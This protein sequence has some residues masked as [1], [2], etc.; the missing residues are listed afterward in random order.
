MNLKGYATFR[1]RRSLAESV[2]RTPDQVAPGKY[3]TQ[4]FV[5]DEAHLLRVI[6]EHSGCYHG[7]RH[8]QALDLSR[9]GLQLGN[10]ETMQNSGLDEERHFRRESNR[11]PG[12]RQ[13]KRQIC[14]F[15][16]ELALLRDGSRQRDGPADFARTQLDGACARLRYKVA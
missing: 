3:L 12:K 8:H 2:H 6:R 14:L 10:F 9:A 5:I 7:W 11:G 1:D 16:R 13:S 15:R 4:I